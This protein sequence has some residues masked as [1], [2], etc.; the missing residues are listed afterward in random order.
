MEEALFGLRWKD[1]VGEQVRV[2]ESQAE[3]GRETAVPTEGPPGRQ[4]GR[5]GAPACLRVEELRAHLGACAPSR[6]R[7]MASAQDGS[8]GHNPSLE[9]PRPPG[10][11]SW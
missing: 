1:E 2:E 7:Q 8:T 10:F 5:A 4:P 6:G 9:D 11:S 3:E